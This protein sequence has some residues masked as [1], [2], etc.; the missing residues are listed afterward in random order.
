MRRN[1]QFL[2]IKNSGIKNVLK[3]RE[4]GH[5]QSTKNAF[6]IHCYR[7]S[8]NRATSGYKKCLPVFLYFDYLENSIVLLLS[9][10]KVIVNI[11]KLL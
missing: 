8:Q 2:S 1:G 5:F 4:L 7:V 10:S 3:C 9:Q 6:E 11:S